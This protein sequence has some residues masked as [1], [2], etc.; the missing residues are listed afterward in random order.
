MIET[1]FFKAYY[2]YLDG[3][4]KDTKMY[5]D[6]LKEE[7]KLHPGTNTLNKHYIPQFKKVLMAVSSG[8]LPQQSW[9]IEQAQEDPHRA[10]KRLKQSDVVVGV[11]EQCL[12]TLKEILKAD[13]SFYL[14][15]IEHP[16]PPYGAVDMLYQDKGTCYPLEVKKDRGEHDL[17]GQIMKYNLFCNKRLHL[18][19]YF[20]VQP[21][22]VC[23]SYNSYTLG[24]LKQ[25]G[26]VTLRYRESNGVFSVS[27]I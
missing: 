17:I 26:V 22:T 21:I 1:L 7:C 19:H 20:K 14:H 25:L 3:N 8:H 13:H 6:F 27:K 5:L 10:K 12:G 4:L 9:P 11:H 15:N 2:A 18:K 24:Q 16:C 23:G